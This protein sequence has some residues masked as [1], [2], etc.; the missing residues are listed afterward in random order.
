MIG[1]VLRGVYV[2]L[3]SVEDRV[4]I[5]VGALGLIDFGPGMY[6]YVGS[7]LGSHS[8]SVE[9]RLSRHYSDHKKMHWHIDYILKDPKVKFKAAIFSESRKAQECKLVKKI[10]NY[11][12][13][14]VGPK[15]FGSSDCSCVSHLIILNLR[16]NTAKRYLW[17]KFIELG[18][19]PQ[20][21]KIK[22]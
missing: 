11:E 9:G 4:Q 16:E 8:S 21:W 7:A 10:C 22:S 17:N 5:E 20:M 1:L 2:L 6:A 15:D 18:L 13:A 14:F 3:I 12:F 19:K